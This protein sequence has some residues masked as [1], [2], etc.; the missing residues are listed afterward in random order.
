M[1]ICAKFHPCITRWRNFWIKFPV[2]CS[3]TLKIPHDRSHSQQERR[4]DW[5]YPFSHSRSKFDQPPRN[6]KDNCQG[7]CPSVSNPPHVWEMVHQ[8][9]SQRQVFFWSIKEQLSLHNGII[10][11]GDCF[12]V[13]AILRRSLTENL[14]EAYMGVESTLR[15]ARKSFWWPGLNSQ[16]KQFTSS[17]EVCQSIKINN[18]TE[19]L[20]SHSI[21][22][23]PWTKSTADFFQF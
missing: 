9:F 22:Y 23:R 6:L 18:Q 10:Y 4:R 2:S 15:C 21:P 5:N 11:G 3:S 12:A 17:C 14:H 8:R 19:S 1:K 7:Q 20:M 13:P 16:L